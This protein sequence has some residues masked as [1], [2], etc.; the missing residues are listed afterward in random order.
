ME[1]PLIDQLVDRFL[2]CPLPVSVKVDPCAMPETVP[3]PYE[4]TGT[5]L[6]NASEAKLVLERVLTTDLKLDFEGWAD[7]KGFCLDQI[8]MST[9]G[10][11]TN[12]YTRADTRL[13]YEIWCASRG[14]AV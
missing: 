7:E 4:R 10:A 5:N 14:I 12:P 9:G 1:K 3:Y 13:A 8:F 2:V 11:P 6:M